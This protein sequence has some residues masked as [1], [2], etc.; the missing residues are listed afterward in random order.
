MDR[1]RLSWD[2]DRFAEVAD[3]LA[4]LPRRPEVVA[5]RLKASVHGLM[6][7]IRLWD[8][9][10]ETLDAKR[11]AWSEKET[12]TACDLLGIAPHLRDG[13]LPFDPRDHC[14]LHASRRDFIAREVACLTSALEERLRPLDSL[15]REGNATGSMAFLN[16]SV[17][18]VYRYEREAWRRYSEAVKVFEA[19]ATALRLAHAESA[20]RAAERPA[21]RPRPSATPP[22][23]TPAAAAAVSSSEVKIVAHTAPTPAPIAS[24]CPLTGR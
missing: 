2:E 14:D 15:N 7:M 23:P 19:E 3:L 1:A 11:G 10:R 17:Q 18:L 4:A 8:Q 12:A 6:A 9:L 20:L 13:R 24:P 22:R 16:K 5:Y 21:P